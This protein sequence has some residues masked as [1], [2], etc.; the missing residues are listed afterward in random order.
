MAEHIFEEILKE[1]MS[2]NDINEADY[3]KK[4]YEKFQVSTII[5]FNFFLGYVLREIYGIKLFMD[6]IV[7]NLK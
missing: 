7:G 1:S 2:E 5:Y 6:V 3:K 4:L